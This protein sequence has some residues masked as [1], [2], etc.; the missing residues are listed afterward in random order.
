MS[1]LVKGRL[2]DSVKV[3]LQKLRPKK[4]NPFQYGS[5]IDSLIYYQHLYYTSLGVHKTHPTDLSQVVRVPVYPPHRTNFTLV[6]PCEDK[7]NYNIQVTLYTG[8]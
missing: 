2:S 7:L 1:R 6:L 5:K 4:N 8:S 3:G